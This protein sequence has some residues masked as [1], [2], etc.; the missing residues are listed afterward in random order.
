MY[1]RGIPVVLV[2]VMLRANFLIGCLFVLSGIAWPTVT[3]KRGLSQFSS[4]T[5]L[6]VQ[7]RRAVPTT[8]KQELIYAIEQGSASILGGFLMGLFGIGLALGKKP[9]PLETPS[10]PPVNPRA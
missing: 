4:V 2:L 3:I 8:Q 9:A 5:R 7:D 10:E 1:G 6:A